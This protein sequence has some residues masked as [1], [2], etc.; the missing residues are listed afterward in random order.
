MRTIDST[1]TANLTAVLV[2]AFIAVAPALCNEQ[3]RPPLFDGTGPYHRAIGTSDPLAQRYF[4]QGMMF[5]F[6]FNHDE[7]TRSFE[8]SARIDTTTMWPH[9]GIALNQGINYN[10]P[11]IN[12][13]RANRAINALKLARKNAKSDLEKSLCDA[14]STRYVDPLPKDPKSLELAYSSAMKKVWIAHPMDADVGALYAESLMNLRP[15]QLWTADGKPQ[16]ETPEIVATLEAVMKLDPKHPL[17]LHLYIHAMEAS[18]TP[19][20]ADVAAN[21]LRN[22]HPALGHLLHMPSHIDIRRGRWDEAIVAN[23][24]AIVADRHYA[25]RSKEQM[26]YRVY[27]AHNYHMAGFAMMML[28]QGNRALGM[29]RQMMA[30]VP[31]DFLKVPEQAAMLDNFACAPMEVMKRFGM[32]DAIVK[33]PEPAAHF[34]MARAMRQH[35]R[36]VAF[37][38]KNDPV[39]ARREQEAFDAIVARLPKEAPFGNNLASDVFAVARHMLEG[40]ILMA[41]GKAEP[42]LK[43]LRMAVE[44]ESTLRYSEPPDW[45]VPVRHALGAF[46]LREGKLAEAEAVYRDDLKQWPNNGWSLFGLSD[47][48]RRQGKEK[49][50]GEVQKRF[51]QVWKLADVKL[52]LSCL[53][54]PTTRPK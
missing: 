9:W 17:A 7:A 41:E 4:N 23:R 13:A 12:Q 20:K 48:L 19:E 36:A 30:D 42:G 15:W 43:S 53:C 6:A 50:A 54:V 46:L 25:A 49:E 10:D 24:L 39:S 47:V 14:L 45:I 2:A 28:G 8:E 38:A 27:M 32:W 16:P 22:A 1:R 3:P 29:M 34:P 44:K 11:G 35:A 18:P 52:G 26:I 40:E 51:E 33:E 21:G 31:A 37:A 5:T